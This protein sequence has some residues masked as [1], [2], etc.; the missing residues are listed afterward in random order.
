M[1]TLI[2]Y[3][4]QDA[5]KKLGENSAWQVQNGKLYRRFVFENF[6]HAFGFISQ[7]AMLAEKQNHHPE[8]ANIFRTVDVFLCTHEADGITERDFKLQAAIDTLVSN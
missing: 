5:I 7:V 2:R 4:E 6:I 1:T 8:W 3:S